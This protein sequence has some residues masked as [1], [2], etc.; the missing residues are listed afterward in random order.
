MI[1]DILK[2]EIL[3]NDGIEETPEPEPEEKEVRCSEI[4][5]NYDLSTSRDFDAHQQRHPLKPKLKKYSLMERKESL[6]SKLALLNEGNTI[7]SIRGKIEEIL[8]ERGKL[9]AESKEGKGKDIMEKF[10]S[11]VLKI[12]DLKRLMK[13]KF[14]K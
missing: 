11:E 5:S 10:L 13:E 6:I 3:V 1:Y 4:S 7:D 2:R 9:M 8:N 12:N 14:I